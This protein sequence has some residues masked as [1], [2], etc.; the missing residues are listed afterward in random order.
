MAR[1]KFIKLKR[2]WAGGARIGSRIRASVLARGLTMTDGEG[3]PFRGKGGD[4]VTHKL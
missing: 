2:D 3:A 1:L 4:R